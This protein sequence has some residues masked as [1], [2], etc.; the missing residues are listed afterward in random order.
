LPDGNNV[1][2][3]VINGNEVDF[4]DASTYYNVSTVNYLAAGSCNFNNS[5]VTLWPLNQILV[6]SQLYVRDVVIDYIK[7]HTP[8]T[9]A[10]EGRLAFINDTTAPVI[11][12]DAPQAK[13]YL[14]SDPL[15]LD[16]TVTDDI[17]GVKSVVATLDG[18][19]AINGQVVKLYLY[20]AGSS[21]TFAVAAMDK[22]Y[23]TSSASVTFT[24]NA[25]VTS[26]KTVLG[27]LYSDG[28]ITS[29]DVYQGLLDK[30]TAS[31]KSKKLDTTTNILNAFIN[32]V[33]AQRGKAITSEAADLL[34]ADVRYVLANL[35]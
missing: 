30:L 29:A 33:E 11:T 18:T 22:A 32:Q 24:V 2:S 14:N 27:K 12:I 26:M 8:V 17:S 5:G 19:T 21:H 31:E 23:N 35:K 16:F 6:D 7:A 15:T 10:V 20:P 28:G 4:N 13:V 1:V 25:T 9:P 3:L 34:L